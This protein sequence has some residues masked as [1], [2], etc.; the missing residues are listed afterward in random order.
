[1]KKFAVAYFSHF[2]NELVLEF[3]E[4][5]NFMLAIA[6]HSKLKEFELPS[7][8]ALWT[9]EEAKRWFFDA[10]SAIDVKEII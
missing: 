8:A 2:D 7:E 9:L 10:D 4:A 3:V 6:E 1:M 5:K